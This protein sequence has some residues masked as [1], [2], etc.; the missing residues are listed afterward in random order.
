VQRNDPATGDGHEL[1]GDDWKSG[2]WVDTRA[3]HLGWVRMGTEVE[4]L[5]S[6][7]IWASVEEQKCEYEFIYA[8]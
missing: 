4:S 1:G 8:Y 7:R 2:Q 5:T 3:H 6:N